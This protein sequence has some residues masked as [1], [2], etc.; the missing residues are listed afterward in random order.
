M[1]TT[2]VLKSS[3]EQ[4]VGAWID[5]LNQV[6]ID[7]LLKVLSEQD[8]NLSDAL[9][10]IE[11]AV[12]NISENIIER[13]RGGDKG[14]HGFIAEIAEC[15]IGNARERVAGQAASHVWIDDNGPSDIL[16]GV[17]EIQQKFVQSGGHLSLKAVLEHLEHYP[18]YIAN[19]GEYQIPKDHYDKIMEYLSMPESVANKLP[20]SNGEF[21]LRQWKEVH[22]FFETSGV[23]KSDLEPSALSYDQVQKGTITDTLDHEKENLREQDESRRREAYEE[24]KPTLSEGLKAT[25]VGAAVEGATDFALAV[26]KKR[27]SG[28]KLKDFSSEDW[29][30]IGLQT[31][32]GTIRGGVRGA[33]VYTLT[34]FT[35]TPGAVASAMVTAGFGVAQQVHRFRNG[36]LSELEL[37]E[38]AEIICL[39][40]SVSALSTLIG[41]VA[42]PVP[43]LG[44]IIGNSIGMMLYKI[45]KDAFNEKEKEIINQYLEEINAL[46][47]K[48]S[49][50]YA[51]YIESLNQSY[52]KF[53]NILTTAFSANAEVAF[54]GSVELALKL[55]VPAEDVLDSHAK[56]ISYFID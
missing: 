8:V 12:T 9:S 22:E 50:E 56:V 36:T 2:K 55:G 23:S 10:H 5:Y 6:R 48:L 39:D 33:T 47:E 3:Q 42:I 30:E 19:G 18:D 17:T 45:G 1:K 14:M 15:G 27:K 38:N 28:K 32:K 53:L 24:S 21:S 26:F 52:A 11:W 37:I 34:N 16:R 31:G 25:A 46:E 29:N 4:A 41:Q 51:K 20:T 35:A 40:A 49:V 13:N 43:I 44:A 54:A 7:R